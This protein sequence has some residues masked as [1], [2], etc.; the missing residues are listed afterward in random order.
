DPDELL[1][2]TID[3]RDRPDLV[4][5]HRVDHRLDGL[6]AVDADHVRGHD[7]AERRVEQLVGAVSIA[8]T[9]LLD[10]HHQGDPK[11]TKIAVADDPEQAALVDDRQVANLAVFDQADRLAHGRGGGD[12]QDRPGHDRFDAHDRDLA[13]RASAQY[14][15]THAA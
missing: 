13:R 5:E 2:V 3:D 1:G 6:A 7:F 14:A 12:A 8:L 9:K 11:L 10:L 15:R 4:L